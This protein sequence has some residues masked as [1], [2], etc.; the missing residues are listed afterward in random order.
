MFHLKK[1]K[2]VS[3]RVQALNAIAVLSIVAE[4][5]VRLKYKRTKEKV[6]IINFL[7]LTQCLCVIS[8]L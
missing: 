2:Y 8:S 1:N 5:Y 6:K 3:V 7:I 4:N